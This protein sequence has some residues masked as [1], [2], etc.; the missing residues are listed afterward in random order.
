M[1]AIDRCVSSGGLY[2]EKCDAV[3]FTGH[4]ALIS[5]NE[6]I[7]RFH[8]ANTEKNGAIGYFSLKYDG[9]RT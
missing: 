1:G 2:I 6:I 9:T 4:N 8:T 7:R 3:F 5:H